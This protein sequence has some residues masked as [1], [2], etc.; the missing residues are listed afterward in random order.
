MFRKG[1]FPLNLNPKLGVSTSGLETQREKSAFE[2]LSPTFVHPLE[3]TGI[4]VGSG[5]LLA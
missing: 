2:P 5:N 4:G 1:L 3:Y